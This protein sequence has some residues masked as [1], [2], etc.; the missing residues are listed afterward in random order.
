[1]TLKCNTILVLQKTLAISTLGWLDRS[2]FR[3]RGTGQVGADPGGK[4][5]SLSSGM[6]L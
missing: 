3:S 1:M 5:P 6:E 2:A 4:K